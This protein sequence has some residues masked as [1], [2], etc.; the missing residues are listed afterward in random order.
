MKGRTTDGPIQPNELEPYTC[1]TNTRLR[2]I[3]SDGKGAFGIVDTP[4]ICA[5]EPGAWSANSIMADALETALGKP[6]FTTAN[7]LHRDR[8]PG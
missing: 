6:E 4:L 2:V 5:D 7:Y 3:S 1:P 8:C